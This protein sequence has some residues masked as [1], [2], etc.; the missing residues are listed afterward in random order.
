MN[1]SNEMSL[2]KAIEEVFRRYN[3]QDKID[4]TRIINAWEEVVGSMIAGHTTDLYV[5]NNCLFI[6]LDS[7]VIRNEL[8]YARDLIMKNLNKAVGKNIV[9]EIVLR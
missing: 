4:G 1:S 5:K 9:K 6:Y 3:L 7:D 2:G 8:S